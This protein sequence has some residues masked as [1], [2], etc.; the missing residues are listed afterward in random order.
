MALENI[1]VI[2][3]FPNKSTVWILAFI[4]NMADGELVDPTAVK[5]TA[6]YNPSEE[7]EEEDKSMT[8]YDSETGIYSYFFHKGEEADP[9]AKGEWQVEGIVVDG[10]GA[11]AIVT[12]FHHSFEVQ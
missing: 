7:A 8:K 4:Y 2:T 9:L 1:E 11:S 12:P 6:I 5:I 10:S 3:L